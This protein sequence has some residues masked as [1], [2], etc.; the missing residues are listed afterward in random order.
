MCDA[1]S[2]ASLNQYYHLR[3][4]FVADISVNERAFPNVQYARM[5]E[6][7]CQKIHW[8]SL[9][10]LDRVG[11][12]LFLQEAV[13]LLKTAGAD[14]TDGNLV[15]IPE[16][17]VEKAFTTAP[18]RVVLYDRHGWPTMPL[19]G[20]RCFYGPGSDCLRILDHRTGE[21]RYPVVQ[22]VVEGTVLCDALPNIDFVMSMVLPTDVDQT[23]ADR[24]QMEAML[25]N[26]TK[27]IIYVTYELGGCVDAVAMAE[28][29]AGGADN[30]RRK[31][32]IACYINVTSGL[33]QNQEA[34][35]KLL[36]LSKKGLPYLWIPSSTAGVTA[37]VTPAGATALDNAGTLAGLVISQLVREGTPFI[38]PGMDSA[39][40]DLKTMAGT[41]TDPD[42]GLFQAMGRFYRLPTFGLGGASHAKLSDQQAAAEAALTLLTESLAGGNLIHD[43]GYL[44]AGLIYSLVQ[45][46]LCDQIVDWIQRFLRGIEVSEETLAV[47]QI[48]Q[49]GAEGQYLETPHTLKHYRER[50]YP[51]VFERNLYSGWAD[52]GSK[53]FSQRAVERIDKILG[54]HRP[55]PLA[56]AVRKQL[57]TIVEQTAANRT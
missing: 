50:W 7:Q 26:T 33:Y 31:P 47:E 2:S 54:E 36:F 44:D 5:T 4:G 57:R 35:E 14:V 27:P 25:A 39:P 3:G 55:E 22:D 18:K 56:D 51:D 52:K 8:A 53:S 23:V 9:D 19:Q 10:L 46:V 12:R 37:P 40:L 17:M 42:R 30:L 41:Y 21:L 29:V 32:T 11:V 49:A 48:A 43:L 34:L 6:E 16:G 38:M 13:D 45:L 28:A 20:N 15:R 1:G 24:Y